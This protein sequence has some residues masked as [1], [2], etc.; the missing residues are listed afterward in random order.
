M[1]NKKTR[2]ARLSVLSNT[3]LIILKVIAGLVSGSVSILSE[4]IHSTMDLVAA[5][6][7]FLSVRISDNP[8]DR[9]HP[10]GHG[11]VENVSGVIEALL[12]FV[13]AA[14]I[15]YEA[16]RRMVDHAPVE[17]LGLAAAVMGISALVNT[18]VSRALYRT[19]RETGSVA[20]EADALHL[21]TDVYTSLGVGIGMLL[22]WITGLPI[23]DPLVAIAVAFL[24]LFE[25]YRLLSKAFSPLLDTALDPDDLEKINSV[26]ETSE[27]HAHQIR[28]RRAGNM[29]FADMHLELPARLS[30][31]KAH[32]IC[33]RLEEE[34]KEQIPGLHVHI[35]VE[36]KGIHNGEPGKA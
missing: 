7:A 14:W 24:I 34:L 1:K 5:M 22:I 19:A 25:S 2:V 16:I 20:L 3:L 27:L 21:K 6:I 8:P 35:H 33:D 17:S 18:L 26:L 28:T 12:I 15:I 10:Y 13:A 36:P 4:A 11:K 30:L 29:K 31:E 23:L 32:T 9:D